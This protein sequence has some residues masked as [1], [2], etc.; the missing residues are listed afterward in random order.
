MKLLEHFKELSLHPKNAEELKGMI[1]RLAI[2]GKLT[3]QWREENPDVES[4]S[5]LL[6]LHKVDIQDISLNTDLVIRLPE[7]W[8]NVKFSDIFRATQGIQLPK[9]QQKESLT[10]GYKKYLYISDF[11]QNGTPKYVLD[12][13]PNKEVTTNTL[14]MTNTGATAGQVLSGQ[15]G[16]LSNNLFKIDYPSFC[17][18]DYVELFLKSPLFYGVVSGTLKGGANPHMGHKRFYS[19]DFNLPPTEE[20]KAIVEVVNKLFKEVDQLESLTK[21]RI[22]LKESFVVSAKGPKIDFGT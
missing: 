4:A 9:N 17:I 15:E 16:I 20:Q 3:A 1:L 8:T 12:Q 18:R 14:V 10:K 22:H 11:K 21:E 13:Y 5:E 6:K 7:T 19:W 2:Q